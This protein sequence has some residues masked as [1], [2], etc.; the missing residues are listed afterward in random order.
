MSGGHITLTINVTRLQ[1]ITLGCSLSSA[2]EGE[3]RQLGE[4]ALRH[5]VC[6]LT[7]KKQEGS[8]LE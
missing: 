6:I 1:G 5:M 7:R 8:L 4:L 3:G 2:Q